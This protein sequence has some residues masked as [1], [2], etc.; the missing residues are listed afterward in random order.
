MF[1]KTKQIWYAFHLTDALGHLWSE[2]GVQ[3]KEIDF[4]KGNKSF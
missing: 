1:V 4:R 3:A 2:K